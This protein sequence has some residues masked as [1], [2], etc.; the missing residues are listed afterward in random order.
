VAGSFHS[1]TCLVSASTVAPIFDAAAKLEAQSL[2]E[3]CE[4][5]VHGGLTPDNC[6]TMLQGALLYK[7][8]QLIAPCS[9]YAAAKWV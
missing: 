6:C 1:G 5:W 4:S 9:E 7:L 2:A 3:A 8:Q